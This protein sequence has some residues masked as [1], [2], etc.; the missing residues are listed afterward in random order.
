MTVSGDR[1]SDSGSTAR[2]R[3]HR[4]AGEAVDKVQETASRLIG[5][6]GDTSSGG[7]GAPVMDQAAEQI[8]SRLDMGKDYVVETVTGLAQALRQTG[9]HLRDEGSQPTFAQYAD[10]GAEQI[11]HFGGYLK[12]RNTSE[13]VTDVEAFARRQPMVFAGSAFA[14]GMLAVRFLRSGGQSQS[15]TSSSSNWSNGG[16][17]SPS[18]SPRTSFV[19]ASGQP[20]PAS[21][22]TGVGAG[23]ANS[24]SSTP[25]AGARPPG[26]L[27]GP[28]TPAGTGASTPTAP[29]PA[30]YTGTPAS[31][32]TTAPRPNSGT[33]APTPN[34][35]TT[36][37]T[38]NPVTP[39]PTPTPG[40]TP[41]MP[42]SATRPA[43]GPSTPDRPGPGSGTRSQP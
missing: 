26:G 4:M 21:R 28:G 10:R 15:Q 39:A 19:G 11:E 29:R 8:T 42:G 27:T 25:G 37:P 40:T 12:R 20:S 33:T 17:S 24:P 2:V 35:G 3:A 1:T 32:G 14:L 5:S 16:A 22:G 34:S 13:I 9:Q 30:P 43:S 38:P 18:T 31:T 23:A 36:A 7:Q 6:D 41:P